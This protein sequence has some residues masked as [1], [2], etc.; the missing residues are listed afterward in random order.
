MFKQLEGYNWMQNVCICGEMDFL[1]SAF[2][3]LFCEDCYTEFSDNRDEVIFDTRIYERGE[4]N[5]HPKDE[6]QS[7]L[8]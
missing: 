6:S 2:G 7:I 1:K 4:L 8:L 5:V 3:H